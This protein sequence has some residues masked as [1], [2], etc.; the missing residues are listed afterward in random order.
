M[1]GIGAFY[2]SHFVA[3]P[4]PSTPTTRPSRAS[5]SG[6]GSSGYFATEHESTPPSSLVGLHQ[7]LDMLVSNNLEQT[8]AMEDVRKENAALREQLDAVKEDM[9]VLHGL[10]SSSSSTSRGQVK[11]P[12]VVSVS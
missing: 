8:S 11:I 12:P 6:S 4:T 1:T 5:H 7:K 10:W 3:S 9:R 2:G